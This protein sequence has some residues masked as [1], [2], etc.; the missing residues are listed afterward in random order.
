MFAATHTTPRAGSR[1]GTRTGTRTNGPRRRA[2]T[3]A[4]RMLGAGS[5]LAAPAARHAVTRA[6]VPERLVRMAEFGLRHTPADESAWW[7]R[8]EREMQALVDAHLPAGARQVEL[9]FDPTRMQ[10]VLE[11]DLAG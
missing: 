9:R 2:P 3:T 8:V 5:P 11:Y 7:R 1:T 6:D 4:P 10:V